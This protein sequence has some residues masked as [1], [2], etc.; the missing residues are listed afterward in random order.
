MSF[1]R[2]HTPSEALIAVDF[3]GTAK[4]VP[5]V[6]SVFPQPESLVSLGIRRGLLAHLGQ[7]SAVPDGDGNTAK[8][9]RSGDQKAG[10]PE[11][12]SLGLGGA[13]VRSLG[14]GGGD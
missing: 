12:P 1:P 4:S 11:I 9:C 6:Q 14:L 10:T 13:L 2:T 5:F 7:G 8:G 3:Y